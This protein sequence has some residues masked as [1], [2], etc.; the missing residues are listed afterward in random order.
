MYP[1]HVVQEF[2]ANIFLLRQVLGF[3]L[4]IGH[5]SILKRLKSLIYPLV[6][7]VSITFQDKQA[8]FLRLNRIVNGFCLRIF[9]ET[10][11]VRVL[12]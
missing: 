2:R 10:G 7:F 12:E 8:S 9:P 3:R 5:E 4:H 6:V 1:N 11:M